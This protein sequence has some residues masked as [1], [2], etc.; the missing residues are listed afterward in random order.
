MSQSPAILLMGPTASGKTDLALAVAERLPVTL[1]SVDSAMVYRRMD[2]GTGK[3]PPEVLACHPHH[4]VD[5]LE[6]HESYSAAR[7]L[8]DAKAAVA[9]ARAAG[10][11]PLLVGGTMLYFRT[12]IQGISRLPQ[13]DPALRAELEARLRC[14][15][16]AV[17]HQELARLDPASAARIHRND[18]QRILRALEVCHLTG[19]PYSQA[20]GRRSGALEGPWVKLALAPAERNELHRRI[21][22]RFDAMLAAGLVEEVAELRR[23]SRIRADLPSMRSVG[24][25][26]VWRHL[27]GE[28]DRDTLRER[29]CAATRQLAKRQFTWLRRESGLQWLNADS[30][31]ADKVAVIL[32]AVEDSSLWAFA[33][34]TK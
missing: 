32:R 14:E 10:R 7:F 1:I 34:E 23:D 24:Y 6:P 30:P 19:I 16:A 12:L 31:L 33:E 26:Q 27:D 18:P 15:G 4:L 25:R 21:A 17:L 29:G 28:W 11:I 3:P 8:E 2:I 22:R 9:A 13:A 20:L 5:I